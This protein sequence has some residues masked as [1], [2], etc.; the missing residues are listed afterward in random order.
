MQLDN[1]CIQAARA[2]YAQRA[3][4]RG[5]N[6]LDNSGDMAKVFGM[7]PYP[8]GQQDEKKVYEVGSNIAGPAPPPVDIDQNKVQQANE[9]TEEE[10]RSPK[11]T[12]SKAENYGYQQDPVHS[13][14]SQ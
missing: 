3:A 11:P 14:A 6:F 2:A 4:Q 1:L 8:P 13:C 9:S 12:L 5:A 7:Q 10:R